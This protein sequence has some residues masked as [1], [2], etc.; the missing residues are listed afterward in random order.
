[1]H[2]PPCSISFS[3]LCFFNSLSFSRVS[4]GR[5]E[6]GYWAAIRLSLP[7]SCRAAVSPLVT[8]PLSAFRAT[9][10]FLIVAVCFH[11]LLL[12][13]RFSLTL[14]FSPCCTTSPSDLCERQTRVILPNH[15][16]MTCFYI[17][18]TKELFDQGVWCVIVRNSASRW[19]PLFPK[20]LPDPI[21]FQEKLPE[22]GL[23]S[24]SHTSPQPRSRSALNS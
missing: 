4:R 20:R 23:Y 7:W 5:Y 24:W 15:H 16:C 21:L 17:S 6:S 9:Q 19:Q 12:F 8:K 2:Q 22:S 10:P 13:S 18:R 14:M 3:K 1:M 11:L